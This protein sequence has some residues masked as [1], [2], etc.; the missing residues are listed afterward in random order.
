M[1]AHE[2]FEELCA[3]AVTGDLNAE[4]LKKLGE[5][6]YECADCRTSYRDFH[7][8]VEQGFPAIFTLDATAA[9][10]LPRLGMKKRFAAR[11]A[12]EGIAM[13]QPRYT[14][15]WKIVLPTAAAALLVI[16]TVGYGWYIERSVQ[17]REREAAGKIAVL[18][19]KVAELEG[20]LREAPA[21]IAAPAQAQSSSSGREQELLRELS[22]LRNDYAAVAEN[23]AQLQ[24]RISALLMELQGFREEAQDARGQTERLQRELNDAEASLGRANKDLESLRNLRATDA[25]TIAQQGMRLNEIATTVREQNDVIARER[26][27]LAAGKDIRDLMG[28]RNLRIVDVRDDGTTGAV[29]PLAGRIFYTQ[30]K[31][32]IFYAYDLQNRGNISRVDF[33]VWGKREGRSQPPRSLGILYVDEPSQNRWS[34]KFE[35]AEVLA[36]I[37][38]VFVTMEPRGGS[39]RPTGKQLLSAAFLNETPNHP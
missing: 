25:A 1:S 26:E 3:L 20:R 17:D 29:R 33:Q 28:A 35:N 19:G 39:D 24:S 22:S 4:E 32:L 12:Q 11:A 37:D 38:Q 34:L 10:S 16:G 7:A 18:S 23:R 13:P 8:I 27:L 14:R 5:H 21:P 6:L 2:S 30:G 36:A 31:S 15:L 9:R